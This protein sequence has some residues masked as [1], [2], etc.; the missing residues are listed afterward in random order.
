[1]YLPVQLRIHLRVRQDFLWLLMSTS[2]QSIDTAPRHDIVVVGAS[3]G[4]VEALTEFAASLPTGLP[5]SLFVVLHLPAYGHSVLPE[6]LT[7]RGPLPARHPAD[8]EAI[9]QGCIYVAPPDHHMLVKNGHIL[10]TRGPAENNHR[11]AVDTLFRAAARSYGQVV[12]TVAA[13]GR[14][15]RRRVADLLIA[16]VAH[17][18][19][20]ALYTR[21]PEDL[22]GIDALITVVTI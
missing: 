4:G 13:S 15:Q 18:N 12:A 19:G 6:I 3:A 7:R 20:L 21:N 10:L 16:A 5:A 17:A 1:M 22:V 11:P 2:E 14:S 9:Q 8:G